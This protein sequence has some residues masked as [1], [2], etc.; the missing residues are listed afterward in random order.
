MDL[1]PALFALQ[2]TLEKA[3]AMVRERAVRQG[4]ATTA[5]VDPSLPLIEADERRLNQ[6][7][8]NL[9]SNAIKFTPRGGQVVLSART[10]GDF[11]EVSVCDSGIGIKADEAG[12]IFDEFYQVKAGVTQEGTGLGLAVT[13]RLV[14]LHGGEITVVSVPGEGTT[15]TFTLP[16]RQSHNGEAEAEL[17]AEAVTR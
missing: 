16:I 10:A 4:V 12:K 13:K 7:L 1:H 2:P 14:Q 17:R 6:I 11:V 8:F 5:E 9:L 15:F 3:V